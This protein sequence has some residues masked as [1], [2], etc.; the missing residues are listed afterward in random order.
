MQCSV[1][2]LYVQVAGIK[3][4]VMDT[5]YDTGKK[6]EANAEAVSAVVQRAA[7]VVPSARQV[8]W[9]LWGFLY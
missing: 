2:H 1:N 5:G 9:P 8:A 3:E 6:L 7:A 4:K